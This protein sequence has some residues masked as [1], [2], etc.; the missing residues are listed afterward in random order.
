MHCRRTRDRIAVCALLVSMTLSGCGGGG[1]NA[2]GSAA[3]PIVPN[4]GP[5]GAET[6]L[7]A[8]DFTNAVGLNLHMTYVGSPYDTEFDTWS[9][10]LVSSGVKHVR[11]AICPYAL[12]WCRG[13]ESVRLKHLAAAGIHVDFLTSLAQPFSYVQ[14]YIATMDVADTIEAFEGPNECDVSP[15]CGAWQGVEA[16]WQQELFALSTPSITVIG[17]S[18][19]TQQG[20]A[21]LGNLSAYMNVGNIHDYI[22]SAPPESSIGAASHLSW[23]AA[24]SGGKPVW[25]TE[26]NY[27]TD[28]TYADNGVPQV[29][30]ERYL[31][32]L[33]LEH[34]RLGIKRTYIYQLFDYGKDGGAYMGLL[35][36]KYAPKPAWTRLL[37]LMQTFRDDGAS[38]RTPLTYALTGDSSGALHHLLFQRSD[39]TFVLALWL[40]QSVYDAQTHAVLTPGQ[41]T[42]H[43]GVPAS[44]AS[45]TLMQYRDNGAL[46]NS[47][48]TPSAG[49]LNVPV[50]PLVSILEFKT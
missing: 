18:M 47:V 27:S 32:R 2:P 17:P 36:S 19:V 24:M 28:P 40:A 14:S 11:D 23:A 4:A 50:S 16:Q 5:Q 3:P 26:V 34:L 42:V 44:V 6:P 13:I 12:S 25:C 21:S 37:Q 35:N 33:L 49:V 7:A 15:D 22:G 41:E 8:S 48:L 43:V 10:L 9:P 31:P 20:Y 46:G 39:G 29:V 30:Q 45:A 38:P 1:G